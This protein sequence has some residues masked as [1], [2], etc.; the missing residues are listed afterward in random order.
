MKPLLDVGDSGTPLIAPRVGGDRV[1]NSEWRRS[2][3]AL[4]V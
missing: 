4:V 1:S 3:G 2:C